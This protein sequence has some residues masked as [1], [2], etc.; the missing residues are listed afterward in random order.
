MGE[1][2]EEINPHFKCW[3]KCLSL[4]KTYKMRSSYT[5]FCIIFLS[6]ASFA[7]GKWG[8]F[9]GINYPML[10]NGFAGQI[11]GQ[12]NIGLQLGALY[13]I[14]IT[15]KVSFRPK[16]VFSQQGD[17][18]EDATPSFG[19]SMSLKYVDYKLNYIN[20]PL[21]FKFWDKIYIIAGPQFGFLV[22]Q[23]KGNPGAGPLKSK[24][25]LGLNLGTGFT[26]N[27]IFVEFGA[28]Q[29]LTTLFTFKSADTGSIKDV[30]NAVAKFTLGYN[31]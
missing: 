28:Y 8:A 22:S 30:R 26:V 13:E 29:G 25:D 4:E 1:K 21:D 17:R 31:F 12:G 15:D 18:T 7:Q 9:S 10:T 24:T 19:T 5:L 2:E 23:D 14:D 27:K 16:V 20:I 6:L 3:F 11:S